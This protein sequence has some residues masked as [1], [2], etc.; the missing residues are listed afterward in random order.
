MGLLP[1]LPLGRMKLSLT[2]MEVEVTARGQRRGDMGTG[3][4]VYVL[5]E[6]GGTL[7]QWGSL[8]EMEV[9]A[10]DRQPAVSTAPVCY[11]LKRIRGPVVTT[12]TSVQHH[13]TP[14]KKRK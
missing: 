10:A 12:M 4:V 11:K 7:P 5:R 1:T 3:L 13:M 8:T 2:A 6:G 14:C 9:A